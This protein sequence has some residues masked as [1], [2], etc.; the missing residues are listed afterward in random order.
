VVRAKRK[1]Y[2]PIVLSRQEIDL[3]IGKLRYPYNLIVQLLY[4]IVVVVEF[5]LVEILGFYQPVASRFRT[6]FL[7]KNAAQ[8]QSQNKNDSQ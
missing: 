2:I 7:P 3:I 8:H 1:P 6:R 5:P 4:D